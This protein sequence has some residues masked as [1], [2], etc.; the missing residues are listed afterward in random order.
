MTEEIELN[1]Y[2]LLIFFHMYLDLKKKTY[3]KDKYVCEVHVIYI[4]QFQLTSNVC[5]FDKLS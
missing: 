4:D 3:E 2:R 5:F 1:V